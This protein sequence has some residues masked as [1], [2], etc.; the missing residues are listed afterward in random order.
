MH[1]VFCKLQCRITVSWLSVCLSYFLSIYLSICLCICLSVCRSV[2]LGRRST[3]MVCNLWWRS[4]IQRIIISINNLLGESRN[5]KFSWRVFFQIQPLIVWWVP[6]FRD[7]IQVGTNVI[8][9]WIYAFSCEQGFL[10]CVRRNRN[11]YKQKRV[12]VDT[13]M[14]VSLLGTVDGHLLF[15]F[16]PIN[17]KKHKLCEN[18]G[19]ILS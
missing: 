13:Y 10:L 1:V 4:V 12:L 15:F 19:Y 14:F 11:E 16:K 7:T 9:G 6:P 3:F 5:G 17:P 2:S 8:L 18:S